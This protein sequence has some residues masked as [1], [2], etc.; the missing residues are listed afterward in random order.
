MADA[1]GVRPVPGGARLRLRVKPGARRQR[2]LGAF[3]GALKV[4]V[5]AAPER[6]KANAAV[7]VLLAKSLDVPTSAV[8]IVAGGTS[9][10]KL[11]EISGLSAAEAAERLKVAGVDAVVTD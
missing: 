7:S 11:A 1:V 6:G 2:L 10:D 5:Q 3:G 8:T 4:E 9:R